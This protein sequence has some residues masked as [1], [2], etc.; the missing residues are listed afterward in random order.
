MIVWAA[1]LKKS[2]KKKVILG[3]VTTHKVEVKN[4]ITHIREKITAYQPTLLQKQYKVSLTKF[5]K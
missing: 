4:S 1:N 2:K 3:Q 5:N